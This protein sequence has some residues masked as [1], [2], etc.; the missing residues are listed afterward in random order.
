MQ[1]IS[2]SRNSYSRFSRFL[3]RFSFFFC[4]PLFFPFFFS[5]PF[6]FS[7]FFFLS[8]LSSHAGACTGESVGTVSSTRELQS[9]PECHVGPATNARFS[10]LSRSLTRVGFNAQSEGCVSR[11]PEE[12][13]SAL[14]SVWGPP[15]RLGRSASLASRARRSQSPITAVRSLYTRSQARSRPKSNLSLRTNSNVK[16]IS[17]RGTEAEP[18]Q[19][20]P[21]TRR[22]VATAADLKNKRG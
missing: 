2:H 8:F 16:P 14:N 19:K 9:A 10:G 17:S 7:V 3:F 4:F 12:Q 11:T 6:S 5:F 18:K 21:I 15:L 22:H 13:E 20:G 1:N